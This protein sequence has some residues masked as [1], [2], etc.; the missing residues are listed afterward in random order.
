M[1]GCR[2][3]ECGLIVI[4]P[5]LVNA[6]ATVE[7][8]ATLARIDGDLAALLRPGQHQRQDLPCIVGLP[9]RGERELIAPLH[10]HAA[11]ATVGERRERKFAE[12]AFDAFDL[13]DVVV[14]GAVAATTE[15]V[16][17]LIVLK[18]R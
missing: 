4:G 12:I 2:P 14:L 6:I 9:P 16:A 8:A 15:I 10:E 3:Q 7:S 1:S 11:S 5:N 13:L 18:Q 17:R